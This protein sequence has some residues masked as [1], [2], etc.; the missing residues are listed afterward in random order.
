MTKSIAFRLLFWEGVFVAISVCAG[1]GSAYGKIGDQLFEMVEPELLNEFP[2]SVAISGNVGIVGGKGEYFFHQPNL[3]GAA[4]LIDLTTGQTVKKLTVGG[5]KDL[6]G[7]SV[8]IDGSR[9]VVGFPDDGTAGAAYLFDTTTGQQLFELT[10]TNGISNDF[11]GSSVAIRNKWV[12]VGATTANQ[13]GFATVFNAT[14]GERMWTLN[15]S[16]SPQW[17]WFGHSVA[18]SG[19]FAIIGAPQDPQAGESSGSVYIFDLNTGQ[20]L[21]KLVAPDA[22]PGAFFGASV[23]LDGNRAVIGASG[24]EGDP[25]GGVYLFDVAT[26]AEIRRIANPQPPHV[27]Q[28][29]TDHRRFGTTIDLRGDKVLIGAPDNSDI[30]E[31]G[32]AAY[33]YDINTGAQ[34][35]KFTSGGAQAYDWLG[36]QVAMND[37]VVLLGASREGGNGSA[38]IFSLVP[39][40]STI[41]LM[42]LGLLG[43]TRQRWPF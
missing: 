17:A 10:P 34:L 1:A 19:D 18:I 26:G 29:R 11:F 9:A 32:G 31:S 39:E 37:S 16:D 33:L 25:A 2:T 15:P 6:F 23:A 7:S 43:L 5:N 12:V 3:P 20:Q 22:S 27:G 8:A 41:A 42:A 4:F 38:Y 21:R 13:S 14:T 28:F 36:F 24:W 40:P 30:V 35:F